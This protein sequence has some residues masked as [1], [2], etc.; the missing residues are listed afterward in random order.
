MV[1][2]HS[3]PIPV[4]VVKEKIGSKNVFVASTPVFD[5]AS[6]GETVE[7]AMDELKEAVELFLEE[8]GIPIH[9]NVKEVFTSTTM[10]NL[11]A[12]LS[13]RCEKPVT[14]S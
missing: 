3:F 11:P 10:V 8:P 14:C 9:L 6:Q 7:R 12:E 4:I 5:I 1:T 13:C 2:K